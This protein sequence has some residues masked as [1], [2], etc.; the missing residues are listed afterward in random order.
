MSDLLH[1]RREVDASAKLRL[2]SIIYCIIILF[3]ALATRVLANTVDPEHSHIPNK[4]VNAQIM[5]GTPAVEGEFPYMAAIYL[6]GSYFC[7]GVFLSSRWVLTR[8]YCVVNFNDTQT[9]SAFEL[10]VWKSAIAV[11]Y[12]SSKNTTLRE[13]S[14][15]DV[16]IPPELRANGPY[17]NLAMIELASP[18]TLSR[19]VRPARITPEIVSA[20]DELIAIGWGFKEGDELSDTLQ[21]VRL[22]V[23]SDSVCLSNYPAWSG[24]DGEFVCT[25]NE[26]GRGIC[27]T[28]W[29]GPL[30]LPTF[31]DSNEDFAGYLVGISYT[32]LDEDDF[33]LAKNNSELE[34]CPS[35]NRVASYFIRVAKYIDWIAK[36]MNVNSSELLAT[37]GF[38]G[39]VGD[40]DFRL[41]DD[42]L[43]RTNSATSFLLKEFDDKLLLTTLCSLVLAAIAFNN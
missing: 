19:E 12:G 37:P 34:W 7:D 38:P 17:N 25:V 36:V 32:S 40:D 27:A 30:V 22:T 21:K 42:E 16:F 39:S 5:G 13:S 29:G 28:D 20:G 14:V 10:R 26:R 15:K 8:A 11:R 24:Q 43:S 2:S 23:G 18:I 33:E 31:P 3:Q 41:G 1:R 9:S 35:G 6:G 4:T